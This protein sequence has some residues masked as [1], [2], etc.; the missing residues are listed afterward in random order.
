MSDPNTQD[1]PIMS[2]SDEATHDEKAAGRDAQERAD[3]E[4]YDKKN[5]DAAAES[6]TDPA[7]SHYANPSSADLSHS[8]DHPEGTPDG[9]PGTDARD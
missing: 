7:V 4:F 5:A 3:A 1:E 8:L 6:D 2:G 9:A